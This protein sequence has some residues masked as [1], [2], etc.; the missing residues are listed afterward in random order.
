M[1]TP[2]AWADHRVF[3]HGEQHLV[4]AVE[5]ASLF[6][7]NDEAQ[8]T[9]QRWRT[10]RSV[11]PAQ[12]RPSEREALQDFCDARILRPL[13]QAKTPPRRLEPGQCGLATLVLE[14]AQDCNL[15]CSYCYAGDGTYGGAPTLME[16]QTARRSI[17]YLL[18]NSR[19][20]EELTVIL[21]GGEPLLNL[22]AVEAAVSEAADRGRAAGKKVRFSLTTNGTLLSPDIIRFLN[23]ARIS[24][25][26]SMDGPPAIHDSNRPHADGRGSY[27]GIVPQLKTLLASAP[28][29]VAAR[30]TLTPAQ[31][32]SLPEVFEHLAGLG[33]HEVGVAP[34][35]P[36]CT[37]LLPS[38]EQEDSLMRG[39]E[40][41]AS[42]F[43][44][45]AALGR[46]LPFSNILDLLSRLH[47]GHARPIACGAGYGYMAIDASGRFFPCHR[48]TG[49]T[50]FRAGDLKTGV[51]GASLKT[52]LEDLNEG[53]AESCSR[54][55]ARTLCAGGCHYENHLR[56]NQLGLPRGTS[57]RF[58]RN[59]L[60]L[61]IK[62]YASLCSSD[63]IRS[64]NPLL[65][66]RAQ[67]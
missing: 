44:E 65:N 11:D 2:L 13:P 31:W 60:E 26:V 6:A 23:D 34:V 67:C 64:V 47:G 35:S 10:R 21:F 28:L 45:E 46:V 30:V 3:R 66:K 52:A 56:E 48:L 42:R 40:S 4:F 51:D 24:V 58:I 43:L 19:D 37:S 1:D 63:A 36:V 29:P 22:P 39:F 16:P 61:G 50:E 12:L 9:L 33:F 53:R 15:R 49:V 27:A 57:C 17:R 32:S 62:T 5:D 8:R 41:L 25:A 18:D 7:L 54:C 55:W 38:R 14:V 20:N 59:W